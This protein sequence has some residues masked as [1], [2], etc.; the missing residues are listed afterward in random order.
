MSA[1]LTARQHFKH[2]D[3]VRRELIRALDM[4]TDNQLNFVPR[5]GLRSLG[6]IVRH[7]AD[8]EEGWFRYELTR[9]YD[10]WPGYT[11]AD[12]P[13]VES[14]KKLL[15]DVHARTDAYLETLSFEDLDRQIETTDGEQLSL[16]WIIWHVLDHELHHRGEVFLMLGLMGIEA[17]AI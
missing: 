9:A 13:T 3:E 16:S 14:V 12:Y 8:A 2:W 17:P 10:E 15:S 5:E 6:D 1:Q 4:L 11:A 7:I